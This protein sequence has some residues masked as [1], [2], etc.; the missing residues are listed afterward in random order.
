MGTT[1]EQ[2]TELDD[3]EIMLS[4][5]QLDLV[6]EDSERRCS[7]TSVAVRWGCVL[8]TWASSRRLQGQDQQLPHPH[9]LGMCH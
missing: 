9:Q 3:G 8:T 5:N 6:M 7:M 1:I 4:E 2:E